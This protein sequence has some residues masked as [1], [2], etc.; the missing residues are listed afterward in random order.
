MSEA[1]EFAIIGLATGALYVL[2]GLGLVIIQ[3]GSGVINFAQG[4]IGMA[5]TFVWW[6]LEHDGLMNPV[7]AAVVGVLCSALIGCLVHLLI[8]R[9]L[10]NAALL[11]RVIAT[12]GVLIILQESVTHLYPGP[13]IVIQSLFP[14]RTVK[15]LGATIGVDRLIILAIAAVLTGLLSLLYERSQFGRATA[16]ATENRRALASL[17]WSPDIVAN[18]NW[19]LGSALAGFAGILLAP[20]TGLTITGFTLLVVPA[21]AAAVVGR[22][23]SFRLTLAAGLVIGIAQAEVSLHTSTNGVADAVPL[24]LVV[25]VLIFRG[26]ER[27]FRTQVAQRLPRLG[28]GKV[29]LPWLGVFLV[30]TGILIAI[31]NA[32]W[33]ASIS[34]TLGVGVIVLSVVVVT[35][36]AGQISLAQFAFAGWAVWISG[37]LMTHG[38]DFSLAVII[39]ALATVPLGLVCGIVCLRTRGVS[40][41][42]VTLAVA[43]MLDDL[44]FNNPS[45]TGYGTLTIPAPSIGGYSLSAIL[46][47]QRFAFLT[48]GVFT[49]CALGVANLRRGRSGRELVA[50]RSNERASQ[51]LGVEVVRAK[52]AAFLISS[53]IAG[54]GG[55][56]LAFSSPSIVFSNYDPLSSI[57]I[58]GYAVVGGLGWVSGAVFGGTLET[59]SIGSQVLNELGPTVSNWLPLIGG[60]LIVLT[61]LVAPDGVAAAQA[62]QYR[63]LVRRLAARFPRLQRN[64]TYSLPDVVAHRLRSSKLRIEGLDVFFG[65]VRAVVGV[66]LA[67][68]TGQIVGLIGPNGAGKTTLID[69]ATGYLKVTNGIIVIDD[70]DVTSWKPSARAKA[71]LARSFQSLELFDDLTVLDNL[72]TASERPSLLAFLSDLIW[73][74]R[75][76]LTP[77][78]CAAIK[79]FGLE[80]YL[81]KLPSELPYGVRR[82]VAIARAVATE[83]SIVALDEPAAGLSQ[84]EARELT[85]LLQRLVTQWGMGVLLIDHNVEMMIGLCDYL[86]AL[87]FGTV[88]AEGTPEQVRSSPEVIAA[89]LGVDDLADVPEAPKGLV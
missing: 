66:N 74:K 35:G 60:V 3:K 45:V 70:N 56:I 84:H 87:N 78:T 20:I 27:S 89:Y 29:N 57:S 58:V 16:A 34:V 46:Y 19:V 81:F 48:F 9:P 73:P 75:S 30:V 32:A 71:G 23:A 83:A 85:A 52:L 44:I 7:P 76:S 55:C 36:Y 33:L 39:G 64:E 37:E 18:L 67:V 31:S 11:T 22:M 38:V 53:F 4:A 61:L 8:M 15:V 2:F 13:P 77:S 25:L 82:L 47:P 50:L 12:L 42:I 72:R 43:V 1:L 63:A 49:V 10:K 51:S 80:P 88:I 62:A 79:E 69:A 21:L 59:G 17:G 6:G 41:A 54:L 40:L 5:G 28:T 65:G 68:R 86:Y 24:V 14:T 26:P